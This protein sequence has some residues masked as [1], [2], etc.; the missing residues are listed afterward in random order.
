[1]N[2]PSPNPDELS[3]PLFRVQVMLYTQLFNRVTGEW[4]EHSTVSGPQFTVVKEGDSIDLQTNQ[5]VLAL[6]DIPPRA[7][8]DRLL[9]LLKALRDMA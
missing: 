1:M 7:L 4:V 6:S 2:R 5:P 9:G 3:G 8:L